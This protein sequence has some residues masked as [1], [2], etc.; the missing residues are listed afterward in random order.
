MTSKEVVQNED[1]EK[2]LS[3]E[4]DPLEDVAKKD[5]ETKK[6]PSPIEKIQSSFNLENE[7]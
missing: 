3:K 7:I 1:V 6:D 5:P 4:K 2:D